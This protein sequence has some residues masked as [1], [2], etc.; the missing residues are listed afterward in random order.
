MDKHINRRP[1]EEYECIARLLFPS[2]SIA[3][4]HFGHSHHTAPYTLFYRPHSPLAAGSL[5]RSICSVTHVLFIIHLPWS[6]LQITS[7]IIRPRSLI[8]NYI[9]TNPSIIT[10]QR[11]TPPPIHPPASIIDAS[12]STPKFNAFLDRHPIST[13]VSVQATPIDSTAV[14][15]SSSRRTDTHAGRSDRSLQSLREDLVDLERLKPRRRR[16]GNATES[17]FSRGRDCLQGL[18]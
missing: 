11:V 13:S 18:S 15:L 4:S 2:C 9:P 12:I 8:I 10:H 14:Q 17:L 1:S 7:I 6:P 3:R 16:R 5:D